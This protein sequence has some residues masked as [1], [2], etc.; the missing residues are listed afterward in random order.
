[1]VIINADG[2]IL[3]RLASNISKRLL[4]GDEDIA[5]VNAEKAIISGSKVQIFKEYDVQ[6]KKGTREK[7]PYY[8][9]RA[10]QILKRTIRGMLPYKRKRGRDAY[11]RLKVYIGTPIEIQSEPLETIEN[12]KMSRLSTIKYIR[13]GNLSKKLGAN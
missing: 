3:G 4:E 2:L 7:G 9:K 13:L 10:D 8:P 11:S 1:M 5:I 6:V 12:A